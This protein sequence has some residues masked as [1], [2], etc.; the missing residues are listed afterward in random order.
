MVQLLLFFSGNLLHIRHHALDERVIVQ[1]FFVHQLAIHNTALGQRLPDGDGVD[2]VEPVL[3]CFG[4]KPILLDELCNP[5]LC[6]GPGQHRSFGAFRANRKRGFAVA[7][8]KLM[9]QPCGGI[10]FPSMLFHIADNGVFAL[11]IAVPCADGIVNVIL[12][13]RTQHFMELWV[14]FV[15][16]FPVQPLAELRHIGIEPNQLQI[17]GAENGTADGCIA[18]DDSIFTVRMTAG[19]AV[20]GILGNGGSHHRLILLIQFPN[21]RGCGCFCI[22]EYSV[23]VCTKLRFL[24]VDVL[25]CLMVDGGHGIFLALLAALRDSG[26]GHIMLIPQLFHNLFQPV[27]RKA[28]HFHTATTGDSAGSKV[29]SQLR[30]G[31]FGILA[32]QL[33]EIAHLIQ[34]HIIRVT[35]FDP[36]V[37]PYL[38]GGLL[39][40]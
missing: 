39:G 38:R 18:L 31:G 24:S 28:A 7:T 14:G 26:N 11:N 40:L 36:V 30:S 32:V 8:I 6:L 3:F 22:P 16:D 29:E 5:A 12:R 23:P 2:V 35:L 9:G 15:N 21:R 4:I 20:C 27:C 25:L 33:K 1:L 34:N 19:I 17:T 37:F 10:F 13:E